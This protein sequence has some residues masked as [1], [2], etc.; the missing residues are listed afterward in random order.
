MRADGAARVCWCM[1][2]SGA[3]AGT[4]P[5]SPDPRPPLPSASVSPCYREAEGELPAC[6]GQPARICH[7]LRWTMGTMTAGGEGD[8]GIPGIATALSLLP[9]GMPSC[10]H[11]AAAGPRAFPSP[12][13]LL[14]RR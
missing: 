8:F 7:V 11:T 13:W 12:W 1:Q 6:S 3:A 5:W 2:G 10:W 14:A 9:A 4:M